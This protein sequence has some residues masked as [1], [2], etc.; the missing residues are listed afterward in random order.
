MRERDWTLSLWDSTTGVMLRAGHS[1]GGG[2]GGGGEKTVKSTQQHFQNSLTR[3]YGYAVND[4]GWRTVAGS[5]VC[6]D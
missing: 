4:G 1:G 3:T 2:G 6:S 5:V